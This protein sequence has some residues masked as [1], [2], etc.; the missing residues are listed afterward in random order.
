MPRAL[1]SLSDPASEYLRDDWKRQKATAAEVLARLDRQEGVVLADQVGMG[2]T[3]V[4]MAVAASEIART[5][6]E[7]VM[8]LVPSPVATKWV[9][10]W[11]SFSELY[12]GP[13]PW[14]RC[15]DTPIQTGTELLRH[16]DDPPQR[17]AHLL[18]VKHNALNARM[19]DEWVQLAMVRLA[20]AGDEETGSRVARWSQGSS[21][22]FG[23]RSFT[24]ANVGRLLQA[25]PSD[26]RV[27]GAECGIDM[28]DDPVPRHLLQAMGQVDLGEVRQVLSELPQRDSKYRAQRVVDAQRA[29]RKAADV[30]FRR[31]VSRADIHC[32]LLIV[33]EAH[34]MKHSGTKLAEIFAPPSQQRPRG[35][36]YGAADRMLFLTA[37]P[38]E[39]GHGEFI[40]VLSR[41][42]AVRH[43]TSSDHSGPETLDSRLSRLRTVLDEAHRATILLD[44]AWGRLDPAD[45]PA[46]DDWGPRAPVPVGT[47]PRA[48]TAWVA[49]QR[50]VTSRRVMKEAV[51]TWVIRNERPARRDYIS[52]AGINGGD[53]GEGIQ[54]P[55]EVVFPFLLAGRA[56]AVTAKEP[57]KAARYFAYGLASSF[58]AFAKDG[59]ARDSD[60]EGTD[61]DGRSDSPSADWY[62]AHV[63]RALAECRERGVL[64]PK[65]AA[66]AE[67]AVDLWARGEK[68][69]VFCWFRRTGAAVEEAVRAEI[70]T[71]VRD[72]VRRNPHYTDLTNL[73]IDDELRQ[74]AERLLRSDRPGYQRLH[75]LVTER[76]AHHDAVS[77]ADR[78]RLAEVVIRHLRRPEYL[79]RYTRVHPGLTIE[80]MWVGL[81]G[82]NPTGI[83]L[84][85]RIVDYVGRWAAKTSEDR[86]RILDT[87]AGEGSDDPA[88]DDSSAST[89]GARLD[90][91]LRAHGGTRE[92]VRKRIT[93]QFN[94][95]FAPDVLV[96]SSVMG[97]GI[98]LHEQCQHVIHHDLDWNPSVLEQRTGR[99]DRIGSLI[100]REGT[101][102]QVFEPYLAGTHDEKQFHV[103]KERAAWFGVVMG[104]SQGDDEAATDAAETRL[105][106]AAA[107]QRA[108]ALD[109]GTES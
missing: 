46:F 35:A 65:V 93:D 52:G 103:V 55:S 38:F 47:S 80:E 88:D 101:R 94:T 56:Q 45:L 30:A 107:V 67:R 13:D 37:T 69:L 76:L 100:Q 26:W 97:E 86:E 14:I 40:N 23:G 1:M 95:P 74:L 53:T 31:A 50:A 42:A 98:D 57:G 43:D 58:E 29:L 36:L 33:D 48:T 9:H 10:E 34:R 49:A 75:T 15:V 59:Q 18:I 28:D 51:S 44:E 78:T 17:R 11:R 61:S 96:A 70:D 99:L 90:S 85:T 2:K 68:C 16:L 66:T 4:A 7:Q 8:V 79:A 104:R 5:N 89:R 77:E 102:L 82:D 73:D 87:L 32:P 81:N 54:I 21:G 84:M 20:L 108:L 19:S 92:H 91:V 3:Y 25:H 41:L 27:V 106:L 105:P 24:P 60:E 64:H 62:E 39:L 71:R 6:G 12:L 83:D 22:L 72:L 63:T 109:L